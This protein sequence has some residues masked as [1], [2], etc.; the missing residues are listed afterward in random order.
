M[1]YLQ[2]HLYSPQHVIINLHRSRPA[3]DMMKIFRH[4]NNNRRKAHRNLLNQLQRI[5]KVDD[6]RKNKNKFKQYPVIHLHH[7]SMVL[8]RLIRSKIQIL[9][10]R[11]F[12]FSLLSKAFFFSFSFRLQISKLEADVQRLNQ[13]LDKQKSAELQLRSQ[14]N[15]LK[16][17]RKDLDD[18]R[19]ENNDLKSKFVD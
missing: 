17:I 6:K 9:T 12:L 16:N 15:D 4:V 2:I 1:D 13:T 8:E 5:P 19:T 18:L 3:M 11:K 14:V 10:K 7:M